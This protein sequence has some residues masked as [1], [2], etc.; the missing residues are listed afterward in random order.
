VGKY[1]AALSASFSGN[2]ETVFKS[3][4][5]SPRRKQ[6]HILYLL[7]DLFHSTKYHAQYTSVFSTLTGTIQSFLVDLFSHAATY[8]ATIYKRQHLRLQDLLQEWDKRQYFH[9]GFAQ[10]LRDTVDNAGKGLARAE[11]REVTFDQLTDGKSLRDAPYVMPATHGDPSAP[12]H[13]LPAGNMMPHIV[14]NTATPINSNQM[15][16]LQFIAG[17]ADNVLATAVKA[18]LKESDTIY[19][20]E[21]DDVEDEGISM[22]LDEMGQLVLHDKDTGDVTAGESY[23]GWSKAFCEQLKK[24]KDAPGRSSS[25]ERSTSP[26]KRRYSSSSRSYSRSRS[27]SPPRLREQNERMSRSRTRSPFISG[28]GRSPS[29]NKPTDRRSS[30]PAPLRHFQQ[31]RFPDTAPTPHPPLPP[32]TVQ[33]PPP[34]P[35]PFP[36]AFPNGMPFGPGGM[37]VPPPRPPNYNGPWPP[38]PPPPPLM[39]NT[40]SPAHGFPRFVPPPP[41]PAGGRGMGGPSP[42]GM[43]GWPPPPPQQQRGY[44]QP[45]NQINQYADQRRGGRG[46]R[47]GRGSWR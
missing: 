36:D 30:P 25:R 46:G 42:P 13:E 43:A 32:P 8:D 24:N 28:R 11:P 47:G 41:P 20:V 45:G 26:R 5:P 39:E 6:L 18:L 40:G 22:E 2:T 15:K 37:P 44:G 35:M 4:K 19:G 10:K 21:T 3:E 9:P 16:A 27:R 23:Y 34:P 29:Q 17:P 38:P 12:F 31:P 14:P 1:L 33:N 7:N